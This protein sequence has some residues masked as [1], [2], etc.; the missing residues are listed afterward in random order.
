MQFSQYV[1]VDLTP[2]MLAVAQRK[3]GHLP[4]VGFVQRD[5]LREALPEGD[6]DLIVS[7][8]LFEHL[9]GRGGEV[10]A[11]ALEQ[12][13]PGSHMVLLMVS[14]PDFWRNPLFGGIASPVL[15]RLV[16]KEVYLPVPK[17]DYLA[18]PGRV[19]LR[20]FVGGLAAL[21]VLRKE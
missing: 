18:F 10:V 20:H 8:W 14:R 3:F 7:T 16:P 15:A 21:A 13:K 12:L 11:K 1:G 2:E 19:A 9:Q 5:L 6:F 17:E 4:N